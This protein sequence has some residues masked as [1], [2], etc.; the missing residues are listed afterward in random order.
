[1]F[2]SDWSQTRIN[3]NKTD[4]YETPGIVLPAVIQ[5]LTPPA[6]AFLGLGAVSAAVMSSTDSSVLAASSMFV[7]NIY[8]NIFRSSVSGT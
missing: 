7:R 5:Y 4:P 1:M 3:L 6:V 8:K 2:V